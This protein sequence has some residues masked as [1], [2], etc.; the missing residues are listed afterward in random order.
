MP[1]TSTLGPNQDSATNVNDTGFG[2]VGKFQLMFADD[3]ALDQNG[4][5]GTSLPVPFSIL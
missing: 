1:R 4:C 5:S 3:G 2:E